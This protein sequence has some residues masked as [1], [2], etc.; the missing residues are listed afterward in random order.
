MALDAASR[1]VEAAERLRGTRD[2]VSSLLRLSLGGTLQAKSGLSGL[3]PKAARALV[4]W[5]L[6]YSTIRKALGRA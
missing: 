6:R 1:L 2:F 4:R 3:A 5:A